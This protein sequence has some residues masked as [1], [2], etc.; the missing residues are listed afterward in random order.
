MVPSELIALSR[1]HALLQS[2]GARAIRVAAGLS[3]AAVAGPVGVSAA[4]LSR[5]ENGLRRPRPAVALRYLRVLESLTGRAVA[6]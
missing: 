6:V 1:L 3:L 2:G 5:Y 4:A